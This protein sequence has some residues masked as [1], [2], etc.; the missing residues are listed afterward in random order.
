[1]SHILRV[2]ADHIELLHPEPCRLHRECQEGLYERG[3][4]LE[5][6]QRPHGEYLVSW[7]GAFDADGEY[8]CGLQLVEGGRDLHAVLDADPTPDTGSLRGFP[9]RGGRWSA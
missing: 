9:Y 1:M 5:R 3:D 6:E 7:W 2:T 8:D 4:G